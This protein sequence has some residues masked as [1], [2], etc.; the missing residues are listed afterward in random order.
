MDEDDKYKIYGF[1]LTSDDSLVMPI[2]EELKYFDDPNPVK[3]QEMGFKG[4]ISDWSLCGYSDMVFDGVKV[5]GKFWWSNDKKGL[6]IPYRGDLEESLI[7]HYL[8]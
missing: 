5:K 8:I 4:Y 7:M 3:H 2:R 6:D 1:D